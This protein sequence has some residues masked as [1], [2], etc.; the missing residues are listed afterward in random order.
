[1]SDKCDGVKHFRD[2]DWHPIYSYGMEFRSYYYI[3]VI[4]ELSGDSEREGWEGK[5]L[6]SSEQ[7]NV[8]PHLRLFS[9]GE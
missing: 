4:T 8:R 6:F 9:L 7:K 1:M 5:P 2:G 3:E